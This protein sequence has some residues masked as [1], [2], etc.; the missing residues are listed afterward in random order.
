MPRKAAIVA[1]KNSPRSQMKVD[2]PA[3][4]SG[5]ASGGRVRGARSTASLATIQASIEKQF[6]LPKG[7]VALV[8]PGRRTMDD[9]AVVQDLR[10]RWAD[11]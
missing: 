3:A 2:R 7:S 4:A 1:K 10:D 9:T 6:K 5:A 11:R 8:A